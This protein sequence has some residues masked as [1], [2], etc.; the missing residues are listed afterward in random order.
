IAYSGTKPVFRIELEDGKS[1]TC[2]RDH[3][4]LT[5]TGWAPLHEIVGGL[6]VSAGGLAVFGSHNTPIATN[7]IAAYKDREWLRQRY[8]EEGLDQQSIGQLAGVTH[9]TIRVWVRKHQLQKPIGSWTIGRCPWNKGKRY[10]AGW[11]HSERT[12][13]LFSEQKV[14]AKN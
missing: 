14:G 12:R 10:Q 11:K 1:I 8:I 9:H 4:F 2:S 7:G 5:P 6:K 3:R 13:K